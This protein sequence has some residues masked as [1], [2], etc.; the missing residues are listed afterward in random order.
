VLASNEEDTSIADNG[1]ILGSVLRLQRRR[2]T[3][4]CPRDKVKVHAF[5]VELIK[6]TGGNL[7]DAIS[8][9][10]AR[11]AELE[12]FRLDGV[13]RRDSYQEIKSTYDASLMDLE[14]LFEA[15]VEGQ[16]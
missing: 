3:V 13:I 1:R 9:L 12:Q 10:R 15:K 16:K 2:Q 7:P 14:A 5:T 6:E 11:M 8:R 4:G